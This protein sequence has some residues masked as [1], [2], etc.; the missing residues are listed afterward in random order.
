MC[1]WIPAPLPPPPFIIGRRSFWLQSLKGVVSQEILHVQIKTPSPRRL[2]SYSNFAAQAPSR[3]NFPSHLTNLALANRPI[4]TGKSIV[5]PFPS[6][7]SSADRS[8]MVRS[9]WCAVGHDAVDVFRASL[10]EEGNG[11]LEIDWKSHLPP[12]PMRRRRPT[13]RGGA[14]APTTTEYLLES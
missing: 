8:L 10:V 4:T 3:L 1:F 11:I 6:H 5:P 9:T 2:H 12:W 13:D 7:I 14:S